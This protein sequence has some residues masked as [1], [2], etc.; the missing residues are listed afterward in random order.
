M[1]KFLFLFLAYLFFT[2]VANAKVATVTNDVFLQVKKSTGQ[3][4]EE[5]FERILKPYILGVADSLMSAN[6]FLKMNGKNEI[7]C[8]PDNLGL[9]VENYM[10]FASE[11]IEKDKKNNKY[12]GRQPLSISVLIR[13]I[14]VFPCK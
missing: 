6:A 9:N 7:F 10:R 3:E 12:N 1:K 5:N 14:D 4:Y 11:Q 13:L 2:N 8:Q